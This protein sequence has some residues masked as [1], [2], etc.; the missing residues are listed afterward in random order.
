MFVSIPEFNIQGATA[1]TLISFATIFVI[2]MYLLVKYS[3]VSIDFFSTTIK[4]LIGAVCSSAA[5]FFT[6]MLLSSLI[7][8]RLS[9]IIAIAAAVIVYIIILLILRAFT[10]TEIKLLPKGEKI[11]KALE[12]WHMIG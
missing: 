5:A 12:K 9:T 2:G 11:A 10:A 4:P 1:G 8:Q 3:K 6:N 7:P